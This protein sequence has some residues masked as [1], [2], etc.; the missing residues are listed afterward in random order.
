MVFVASEATL[1]DCLLDDRDSEGIL[2][3]TGIM[4]WIFPDC[5]PPGLGQELGFV[6]LTTVGATAEEGVVG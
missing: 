2:G 5:R 6:L 1:I 4:G 3:T